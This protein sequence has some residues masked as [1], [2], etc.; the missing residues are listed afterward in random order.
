MN[1]QEKVTRLITLLLILILGWIL[2]QAFIV[3]KQAG[4]KSLQKSLENIDFQINSV[5]GGDVALRGGVTEVEQLEEHLRKLILKIPSEK[6]IPKT[7]HKFLTQVGKGLKV[8]YSLIQPQ[9]IET[10]GR[11]KKL[12]IELK[13][14]ATYND[15]NVYL[16]QLKALPEIFRVEKLEMRRSPGFPDRLEIDLLVSAFVM[17][18]DVE[19]KVEAIAAGAP[20][21]IREVSPFTPK[22][23][24]RKVEA[25]AEKPETEAEKEPVFVLQGILQGKIK[26]A[27]IN[28]QL[29][30]VDDVIG[31]YRI[32]NIKEDSVVLR[33]GS[34]TIILKQEY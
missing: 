5:L 10:E 23:I 17:P 28:E 18:G 29:V 4:V 34:R 9:K 12:P 32:L 16:S 33:K 19:E 11:Y 15:F 13:F 30:S 7:I 2:Y 31:G 8:D 20:P 3:P 6:D 27:I 22:T 24:V 14:S 21:P 26:G 25:A 1:I